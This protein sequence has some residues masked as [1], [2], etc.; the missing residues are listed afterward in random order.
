MGNST[1]WW[2]TSSTSHSSPS[3]PDGLLRPAASWSPSPLRLAT[4]GRPCP[5]RATLQ[6]LGMAQG[7]VQ[8]PN[9]PP[10]GQT[11]LGQR[12]IT[13]I[14]VVAVR[15]FFLVAGIFASGRQ[16][17]QRAIRSLGK[18]RGLAIRWNTVSQRGAGM[19]TTSQTVTVLF[20]DLVGSTEL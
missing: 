8:G 17:V 15:T 2:I 4:I 5:D 19:P 18:A 12:P 3:Q 6:L 20:S 16:P 10:G 7:R 1:C 9:S 11:G 14:R 13:P